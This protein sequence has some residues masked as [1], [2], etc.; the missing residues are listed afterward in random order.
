MKRTLSIIAA[1]TLVVSLGACSS[2]KKKPDKPT[3]SAAGTPATSAATSASASATSSSGGVPT[4]DQANA[5]LLTAADLGTGFS[6]GTYTK[7]NTSPP[8]AAAGS[9]SFRQA[10]SPA[11]DAGA[12]FDHATPEASLDEVIFVY[13]DAATAQA[14]FDTGKTGFACKTGTV[15]YTDGT[16]GSVTITGPTDVST[17]VGG[18][19]AVAYQLANADVQ[20]TQVVALVGQAIVTLSFGAASGADTTSLPNP[21]AVAKA[22]VAKIPAS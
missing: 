8:C 21:V 12:T 19:S 10:T 13:P 1:A 11:V 17:D 7:T 15:Y 2:S 22:A 16:K 3:T 9:P 4:E 5:A 6:A 18:D 14:A 20:S